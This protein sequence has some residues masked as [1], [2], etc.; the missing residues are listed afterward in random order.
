[1]TSDSPI[2]ALRAPPLQGAYTPNFAAILHHF[3][4]SLAVTTYQANRLVLLRSDGITLNTH[5]R[6]FKR[7]M[8][9]ALCGDRLALGTSQEVRLFRNFPPVCRA[10]D[11]P[12]RHDACFLQR[13][14]HIT[15]DVAIHEMDWV[16]DQLWFVNTAFSCLCTQDGT[17]SFIPRWRPPFITALAPEDRCHVNGL[18]VGLDTHQKSAVLFASAF[19][20]TDT[21]QGWRSHKRDGGIVMDVPDGRVVTRGLA[22][23]HSPRWQEG[24]LWV[25]DSG[26]GGVCTVDVTTGKRETVAALSGFTRGLDFF[27]PLTFVGLSQVRETALNEDVPIAADPEAKRNCGVWILEAASGRTVAWLRF[28]DSFQQV[29]EVRVLPRCKWPEMI[30]DDEKLLASAF[31]IPPEALVQV[32]TEMRNAVKN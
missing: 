7:P 26:R 2:Q 27:G 17:N 4:I 28:D 12:D 18:A 14:V 10:L 16:G 5:F 21:S 30:S 11:P 6:A 19:S 32:P 24:R 25:L 31:E 13:N 15:G 23:P 1:M 29:F 3:G 8:G 20:E 22:M 9:L